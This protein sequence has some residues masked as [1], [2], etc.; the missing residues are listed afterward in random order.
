MNSNTEC[1]AHDDPA[2]ILDQKDTATILEL[3]R[4]YSYATPYHVLFVLMWRTGLHIDEVHALDLDDYHPDEQCIE[5]RHRPETGTGLADGRGAER[6]IALATETCDLI[7]DYRGKHRHD[8]TDEHD[9]NPLL[10]NGD[11]R[12]PKSLLEDTIYS[13][14]RPCIERSTL[15][16]A[17]NAW[18]ELLR[19]AMGLGQCS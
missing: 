6:R 18:C 15:T 8:V 10:T 17:V 5:I 19:S 9:R 13:P 1:D 3:Y 4:E 2:P 14:T 16:V 7:A 11:G 12:P